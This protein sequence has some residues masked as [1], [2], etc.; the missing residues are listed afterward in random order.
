MTTESTAFELEPI[1]AALQRAALAAITWSSRSYLRRR[2]ARLPAIGESVHVTTVLRFP[3][4]LVPALDVAPRHYRYP[5]NTVHITVANLDE[6]TVDVEVALAT[7][8]E[9][10]L[11]AVTVQVE[12]LGCSRDTLFL[13]CI[14]G[15]AMTELRA[16]VR[17]A[18]GLVE[19][20]RLTL[21]AMY[22][23]LTF[24]NVVRFDGAGTWPSRGRWGRDRISVTLPAMEVVRTDRYLSDAATTLLARVRLGARERGR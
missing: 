4:T 10:R 1:P 7:L 24:A 20:P 9:Q 8:R 19:P 15:P 6:R 22:S 11:P 12:G 3:E 17:A 5:A 13:R 23:R 16:Q 18:F 21:R 14:H 2:R